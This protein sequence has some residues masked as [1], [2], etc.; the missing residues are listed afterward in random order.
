MSVAGLKY[1]LS[2]PANMFDFFASRNMLNWMSDEAFLKRKFRLK[3][4]YE[5]DLDNPRTFNEKLQWLKLY[6]RK[7]LYTKLVDKYEVRKYIA[8]KIGEQ[9]LIPLVGG[10]WNSPDEI[11]F[12]ALPDQFVLK[13]THDSGGVIICKDKSKLD[14]AAAKAMLA[15]HLKRN[16][17]WANREWPYK[18]VPPRI[19]AEKYMEDETGELRDFKVFCFNGT[20]QMMYISRDA[21][22]D[23][24]TDFFD[25]DFNRLPI[26]M[27]DPNSAILPTKPEGFEEMRRIASI[28]SEGIPHVRTDFYCVNGKIYFGELTFFHNGGFTGIE[29]DEWN[30]KVGDWI[31]LPGKE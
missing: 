26:R 5:L 1:Y 8:E 6:D 31:K 25:M 23:T 12:D 9:Y 21:A 18:N 28:L 24:T 11:D 10:P 3:M 22:V 4:G 17:Y 27:K 16:Y 13:C 2:N 15:K 19:I 14:I 29:P 30:Y 20:P 7:P